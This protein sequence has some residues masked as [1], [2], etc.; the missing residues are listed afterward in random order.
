[1]FWVIWYES[2]NAILIFLW[3][4]VLK[5]QEED[6]TFCKFVH[7]EAHHKKKIEIKAASKS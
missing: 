5:K 7:R 6:R 1:M 4:K 3:I 2:Y